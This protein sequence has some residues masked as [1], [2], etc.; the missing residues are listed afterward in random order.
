M[1][2]P[3][4]PRFSE[5]EFAR[6]HKAARALMAAE[7]VDALVVYGNSGIARHN[8][9]DIHYLSGF[10]GNRNNYLVLTNAGEPVLGVGPTAAV[11]PPAWRWY[12]SRAAR[13]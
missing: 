4:Y 3:L 6:R 12:W 11:A 1:D 13:R 7:G 10:L 2:S 5:A 8:H 9:A